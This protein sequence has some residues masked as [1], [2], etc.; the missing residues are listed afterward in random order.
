MKFTLVLILTVCSYP[1]VAQTCGCAA[2][3]EL[4]GTIPCDTIFIDKQSRLYRQFNCD[5]S[6]ITFENSLGVKRVLYSLQKDQID[7]TGKIGAQFGGGFKNVF[8][9]RNKYAKEL[10]PA[11]ILIDKKTG[12]ATKKIRAI[13]FFSGTTIVYIDHK[14]LDY[15]NVYDIDTDKT[16][17]MLLPKGRLAYTLKNSGEIYPESLVENVVIKGPLVT[18]YYKYQKKEGKNTWFKDISKLQLK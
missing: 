9:I 15:I 16:Q 7:Q 11:Y 18:V 10:P 4:T 3:P 2:K 8:L 1:L 17:K 12:I 13:L 14:I 5:S 6:W